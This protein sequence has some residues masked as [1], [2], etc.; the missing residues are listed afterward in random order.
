MSLTFVSP[1]T[2]SDGGRRVTLSNIEFFDNTSCS[3]ETANDKS[4]ALGPFECKIEVMLL[5]L[6]RRPI[7][8][9]ELVHF[10]NEDSVSASVMKTVAVKKRKGRIGWILST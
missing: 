1:V 3:K 5:F 7:E 10:L 2:T 9:H 4:G 8:G 6:R